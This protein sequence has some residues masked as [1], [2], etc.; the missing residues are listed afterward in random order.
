MYL[1]GIFASPIPYLA[2]LGIYLSGF[3]YV[4][5]WPAQLQEEL[6][7]KAYIVD[8]DAD[9]LFAPAFNTE[10]TFQ[11][12]DNYQISALPSGESLAPIC[13]F[14]CKRP[15]VFYNFSY[16]ISWPVE[17]KVRPPPVG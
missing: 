10:S 5:F 2:I 15:P 6:T 11:L 4:K 1:V 9:V 3:A 8:A 12:D 16:H 14:L 17:H 7:D 13:Y